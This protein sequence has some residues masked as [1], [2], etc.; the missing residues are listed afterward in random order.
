MSGKIQTKLLQFKGGVHEC[1]VA[2]GLE[3]Y[4][5][6]PYPGCK[7]GTEYDWLRKAIED[8]H[9]LSFREPEQDEL[10][11]SRPIMAEV[12]KRKQVASNYKWVWSFEREE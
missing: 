1:Q 6:C 9:V 3:T 5:P 12:Y 8:D 7:H 10:L 11:N 2:S 4:L